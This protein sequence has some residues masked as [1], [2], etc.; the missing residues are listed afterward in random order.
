[1]N[2]THHSFYIKCSII[3]T[4]TARAV[5]GVIWM[6]E[7]SA[8]IKFRLFFPLTPSRVSVRARSNLALF[9]SIHPNYSISIY[10]KTRL[11]KDYFQSIYPFY[12]PRLFEIIENEFI[13]VNNPLVY[14]VQLSVVGFHT[15]FTPCRICTKAISFHS[16]LW[17]RLVYSNPSTRYMVAIWASDVW[18]RLSLV[19]YVSI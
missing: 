18:V 16:L 13:C 15:V 12:A 19:A 6:D 14:S 3:T 11:Q 17:V 8:Q 10:T 4:M 7:W 1:M 9:N 2:C 5:S